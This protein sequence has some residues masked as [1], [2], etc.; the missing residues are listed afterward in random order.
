MTKKI[1]IQELP[2]W[3]KLANKP[4]KFEL[5]LTARCNMNCRHCYINLP[6]K[7]NLAKS[8]EL[9]IHEINSIAD[10]AVELGTIWCLITG[11]EPLL[12]SDF[13]DIY[14][15]LK[16][17]GFLI[18]VFTNASLINDRHIQLFKE[19]PPRDLEVTVYGITQE[20]YEAVT[21]VP[22]SFKAYKRGLDLLFSNGIDVTLKAMALRSNQHELKAITEFCENR[23]KR[24]FRFDLFLHLRYDRN[25]LRNEEIKQERLTPEE[26]V[27]LEMSDKK[28]LESNLKNYENLIFP[29]GPSYEERISSQEV[30]VR[31]EYEYFRK[32]FRCGIGMSDF[33]ISYE[34]QLRLC[35]VLCAPET[36]FNLRAGSLQKGLESLRTKIRAMNT[37]SNEILKTC[38]SCNIVNLCMWCPATA[39]LETGNL[40]G[41][42]PYFCAVAHARAAALEKAHKYKPEQK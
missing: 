14:M 18:T 31:E 9:N 33:A 4:L 38:K 8:K 17:K 32:L 10:E 34:G 20:T 36:T 15:S 12:R 19:Y 35:T 24:P 6:A 30:K 13:T 11:G 25:P 41:E 5:E 28:R 42:V 3:E 37:N 27:A 7:D 40:E 22:G 21:R 26:I 1:E 23:S 2:I 29:E 39:F 16:R